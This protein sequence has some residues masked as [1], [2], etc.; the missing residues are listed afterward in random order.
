LK[1]YQEKFYKMNAEE[2]I[3]ELQ[4]QIDDLQL[5]LDNYNKV[6][7]VEKQSQNLIDFYIKQI[8]NK[9]KTIE[10]LKRDKKP[11]RPEN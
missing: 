4:K 11:L 9:K 2:Q 1:E 5:K 7:K 6:G 3:T 8:D 10:D